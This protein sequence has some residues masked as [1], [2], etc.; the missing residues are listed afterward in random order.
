MQKI[1][2]R[3]NKLGFSLAETIVSVA[4][5]SII[6]SIVFG[7]IFYIKKV[8]EVVKINSDIQNDIKNTFDAF[9]MNIE[10]NG[11]NY[12]Y[13]K[14]GSVYTI[15]IPSIN[16]AL[17]NNIIYRKTSNCYSTFSCI[18]ASFDN[19]VTFQK[20]T[21]ANTN[22]TKLDFYFLQPSATYMPIVT[23]VLSGYMQTPHKENVN[24][25]YQNTV[26]IKN[27]IK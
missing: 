20:I 24:F 4:I 9:V 22:I 3:K 25:Y 17:N 11:I 21:Y 27:Y 16:I 18:E 26:E 13:Y 5:L 1:K 8:N 19:G 15:P 10:S 2:L 7:T 14:S 6:I 12:N 23:I